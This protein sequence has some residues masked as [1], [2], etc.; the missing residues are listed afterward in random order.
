MMGTAAMVMGACT[1]ILGAITASV[2]IVYAVLWIPS[3]CNTGLKNYFLGNG[4]LQGVITLVAGLIICETKE[5]ISSM[6]HEARAQKYKEEHRDA[7]AAKEEE[8]ASREGLMAV[9][10]MGM[11]ACCMFPLVLASLGLGIYGLVQ[12][13]QADNS[14]CGSAVIVYWVLLGL[15]VLNQC[16]QQCNRKGTSDSGFARATSVEPGHEALRNA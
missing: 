16:I 7:E 8:E 3:T 2:Y 4:I 10:K 15:Q 5:V 14:K 9:G 1:V 6:S 12:A 11:L 13:I